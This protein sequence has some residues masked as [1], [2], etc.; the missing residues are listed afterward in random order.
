MKWYLGRTIARQGHPY[1]LYEEEGQVRYTY[2]HDGYWSRCSAN[3]I[4]PN[5]DWQVVQIT[6]QQAQC[7]LHVWGMS[8]MY[9]KAV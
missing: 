4:I 7:T 5:D 6:S 2:L 3:S 8:G 9:Q 1:L